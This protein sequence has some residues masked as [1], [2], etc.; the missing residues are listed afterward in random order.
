MTQSA[1]HL[2]DLIAR[3]SRIYTGAIADVLDEMNHYNQTLPH[4]LK[5]IK[6]GLRTTGAAF[7]VMGRPSRQTDYAA[8]IRPVLQMLSEV[9]RDS[10][11]VYETK[12]RLA[13]HLGELS[14][15]SIKTRGCRGAVI[16]GGVRDVEY[17]LR[18][19]FLVW[20]RYT[21]PADAVPRWQIVEWNCVV[22][23]GDVR[24][25]PGDIIVADYD[26]IVSIPRTIGGEV[27]LK[28]EELVGTENKVRAAVREGMSPLKTFETYGEF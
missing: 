27:L 7:P 15:T 12:D 26:G 24:I 6:F 8:S 4:E 11:V 5:P 1:I 22:T 17:I 23:I 18:E 10:V 21:T 25:E 16:D 2:S 19:D 20:S 13:A 3:F 14:V 28:C 9:P